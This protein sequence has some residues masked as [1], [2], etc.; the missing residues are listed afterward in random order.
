METLLGLNA[1]VSNEGSSRESITLCNR[2]KGENLVNAFIILKTNYKFRLIR[3][4][5]TSFLDQKSITPNHV[6][7]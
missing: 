7:P 3:T 2:S 4:T 1:I 6:N 5:S